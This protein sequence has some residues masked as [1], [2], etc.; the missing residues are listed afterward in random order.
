[1][2]KNSIILNKKQKKIDVTKM[3]RVPWLERC[4]VEA[5]RAK[6]SGV[7]GPKHSDFKRPECKHPDSENADHAS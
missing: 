3:E 5:S 7:Q 2:F 1:M 6:V 4:K